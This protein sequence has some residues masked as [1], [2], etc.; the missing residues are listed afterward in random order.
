MPKSQVIYSKPT[1]RCIFNL[2]NHLSFKNWLKSY[3]YYDLE[4]DEET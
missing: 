1:E 4:S 3:T 2:Y